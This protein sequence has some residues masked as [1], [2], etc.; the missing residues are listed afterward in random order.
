MSYI[1]LHNCFVI[2]NGT[3]R[4]RQSGLSELL[5]SFIYKLTQVREYPKEILKIKLHFF[6]KNRKSTR[7]TF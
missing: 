5:N 7:N 2:L 6:S 4:E 1:L 3:K